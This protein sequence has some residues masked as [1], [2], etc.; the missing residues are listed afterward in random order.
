[1]NIV[2][3]GS[4]G[5]GKSVV[6]KRLAVRMCRSFVDTDDVIETRLG[7]SISEIIER[8]GWSH[9]RE[10]EK[11]TIAEL[12]G[13]DAL[14]IAPGGGAVLDPENVLSL[15]INGLII[16]LKASLPI[17]HQRIALDP[18]TSANRPTLTGKG[19][20]KE[21]E[22]VMASRIHL[23]EKAADEQIDTSALDIETTVD[24]LLSIWARRGA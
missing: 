2:L 11:R 4:R 24:Y 15:K 6:G 21:F 22:E 9:F 20:L 23:Y 13:R 3:I 12:S 1:M 19:A 18:R 10:T 14:V 7:V 5:A 8:N 16:W 17:L